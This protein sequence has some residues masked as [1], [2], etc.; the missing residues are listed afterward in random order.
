[1][2]KIVEISFITWSLM[3]ETAFWF[4]VGLIMAGFIHQFI[5]HSLLQKVLGGKGLLPIVLASILG[6]LLPVCSCGIIPVA[7]ALH[8]KGVATGPSLALCVA[9]PAINPAAFGLAYTTLGKEI[10]IGYIVTVAMAAIF[11]GL[12]ANKII[13]PVHYI[14]KSKGKCGCGHEHYHDEHHHEHGPNNRLIEGFKWSFNTMAVELAPA[15]VYGFIAAGVLMALVPQEIIQMTLGFRG[16]I[17]Y[18]LT[19][20]VGSVMFVCNVGAIPLIATL[21]NQGA[22]P[23]IAIIFL[24]TGPATNVS[25]LFLLN[26]A[27][28][29]KAMFLYVI[30]LPITSIVGAIFFSSFFA[31]VDVSTNI[32]QQGGHGNTIWGI[33]FVGMLIFAL[34][35]P[36]GKHSH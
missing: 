10:T 22:L 30:T 9:A 5:P 27:F 19:A 6:I 32:G 21:I 35:K 31:D 25:Q 36:K 23:F 33:I 18:P 24:I 12:I 2:E 1:M 13:H 28:G 16:I 7:L 20:L 15:L 8:K 14:T 34:L 26:R 17:A 29:S 4:L 11:L 3:K